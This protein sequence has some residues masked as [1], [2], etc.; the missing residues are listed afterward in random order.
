MLRV[1]FSAIC[2][3]G[4]TTAGCLGVRLVPAWREL[5][6][7]RDGAAVVDTILV[8]ARPVLDVA[9]PRTRPGRSSWPP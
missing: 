5:V 6:V 1:T 9:I 3:P 8:I 2:A 4:P 7:W